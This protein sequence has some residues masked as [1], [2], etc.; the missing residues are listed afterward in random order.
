VPFAQPINLYYAKSPD[1]ILTKMVGLDMPNLT[2]R[3]VLAWAT[4]SIT[5]VMTFGFGDMDVRLPKQKTR[6][7]KDG[8]DSFVKAFVNEK[9]GQKFKQSQL[10]LTTAPADTPVIV[11]Q[12][13]NMDNVYQWIVQMPVILT[14]ATNNNV[15]TKNR[16]IVTLTLI[17]VP[18]EDSVDGIGIDNW[19]LQ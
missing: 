10:V 17:R 8:W 7:T 4:T 5:E 12:G 3:A 2:N 16:N 13:L 14:Y 18:S 1:K 15:T 19:V 9:I 6:F 11:A